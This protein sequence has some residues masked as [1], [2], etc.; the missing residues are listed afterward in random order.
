MPAAGVELPQAD[1]GSLR[2]AI[3]AELKEHNMQV[4]PDFVTKIIQVFDCKVR[5]GRRLGLC[6]G[7]AGEG[8]ARGGSGEALSGRRHETAHGP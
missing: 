7:G 4:V 6:Q 1:G 2:R 3:E 8:E 5:A